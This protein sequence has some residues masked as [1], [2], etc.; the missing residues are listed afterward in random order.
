MDAEASSSKV[1]MTPLRK[2]YNTP[3]L[4][5]TGGLLRRTTTVKYTGLNHKHG[6]CRGVLCI[7]SIIQLCP[8]PKLQ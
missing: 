1:S 6:A 2:S 7:Y 5:V 8:T 3:I 4:G